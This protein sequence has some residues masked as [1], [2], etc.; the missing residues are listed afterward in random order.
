MRHPESHLSSPAVDRLQGIS[1]RRQLVGLRVADP[2]RPHHHTRPTPAASTAAGVG[3]G[4]GA[5]GQRYIIMS[6][7]DILL[8]SSSEIP[9]P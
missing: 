7:I 5:L 8:I 4:R 3:T 9:M 1:L 6:I 2:N